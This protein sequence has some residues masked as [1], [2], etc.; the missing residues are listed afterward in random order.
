MSKT[1]PDARVK[2]IITADIEERLSLFNTVELASLL[3]A[4]DFGRFCA[5]RTD[6]KNPIFSFKVELEESE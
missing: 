5:Q 1:L 3:T 4:I 6:I 2:Q